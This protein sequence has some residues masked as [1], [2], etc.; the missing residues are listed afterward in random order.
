VQFVAE[1]KEDAALV[2]NL[3][4]LKVELVIKYLSENVMLK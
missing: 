1:I 3:Q 2:E 4:L